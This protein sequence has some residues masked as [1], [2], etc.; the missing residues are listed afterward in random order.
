MPSP[1]AVPHRTALHG[2]AMKGF[3]S[4]VKF[5]AANGADLEAK[6]ARGRTPLDLA[7][8]N[9]SEDFL[10]QAAEPHK[11]TAE[12]IES[13]IAARNLDLGPRYGQN[14]RRFGGRCGVADRLPGE[15]ACHSSR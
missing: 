12:L 11:D 1:D 8:G 10:R 15:V 9:Y 2:A 7:M 5:L 3:N 4:I 13:L 14:S 6:D